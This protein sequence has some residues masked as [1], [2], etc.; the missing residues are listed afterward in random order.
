M[1]PIIDLAVMLLL[2]TLYGCGMGGGGLLVV[3]LTMVCGMAQGDAQALNLYFYIIASTSAAFILLKQRKV[4]PTLVVIC[5]LSGI[6]GAYLGSLLRKMISVTLLQK[7]FGTMLVLT[8]VSVFF[9][10]KRGEP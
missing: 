4:N 5:A 6:P 10:K 9:S 1:T 7:I 3:Y 2:G 8:G